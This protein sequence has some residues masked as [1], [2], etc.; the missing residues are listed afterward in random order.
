MPSLLKGETIFLIVGKS[1]SGKTSV[2]GRMEN[3]LGA[4]SLK[5]YTTRK[6]RYRGEDS[7]TFVD[8]F[9]SWKDAYAGE[10]IVGWTLFNGEHYWAT[11]KQVDE[12]NTYVIDPDGVEYFLRK[13]SGR[14][15]MKVIYLY[16]TAWQRYKRMRVRGDSRTAAFK[17]ILHDKKAF[18]NVWQFAD[19]TLI[20][21]HFEICCDEVMGYMLAGDRK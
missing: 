6:P 21:D 19:I 14:K 5:S 3:V 10:T 17:R 7:H 12:A 18:A 9:S 13:Y 2:C 4:K 1:G 11:D 20:N 8:E 15:T 16:T